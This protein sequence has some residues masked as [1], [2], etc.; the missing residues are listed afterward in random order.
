MTILRFL[1]QACK[2]I[3]VGIKGLIIVF[4]IDTGNASLP[5]WTKNSKR[6]EGGEE[7]KYENES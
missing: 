1:G 4:D 3:C 2:Q 5:S 7:G 6:V